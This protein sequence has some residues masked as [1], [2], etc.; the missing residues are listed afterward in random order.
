MRETRVS[1]QTQ[2]SRTG[3]VEAHEQGDAL[4]RA[5]AHDAMAL[6]LL[7]LGSGELPR[8][9]VEQQAPLLGQSAHEAE[10]I[11]TRVR[12]D[13]KFE[14]LKATT[15]GFVERGLARAR[16][17][18]VIDSASLARARQDP[19]FEADYRN[20]LAFHYG[21]DAAIYQYQHAADRAP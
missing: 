6:A 10:A 12:A 13:G 1:P 17:R 7:N 20:N 15:E 8:G 5:R 16:S 21:V 18:G 19:Q 11:L 14:A 9:F 2:N 4:A 3:W